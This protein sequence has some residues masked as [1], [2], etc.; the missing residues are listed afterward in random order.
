[1]GE[2]G[3][4]LITGACGGLGGAF[5]R[6]LAARGEPLFL[7]G[8]DQT[9]LSAL[10]DKLRAEYPDLPVRYAACDLTDGNSRLALFAATDASRV[11][12]RRLIY[13]AGADIQ[14]AFER[15]DE[16]KLVFQTRVNFEGAV[17]II[18]GVT[19]RAAMDGTTELLTVGSMSGNCPMPYFVLYSAAKKALEQFSVALRVEL[20]GRAKVTCILPGSMPTR[21][22]IKKNI[23]EHGFWTRISALPPEKVAAAAL[24]AVK[25][26][27][28]TKTIGFWNHIIRFGTRLAPRSL[29]LRF[30]ARRWKKTEKDAF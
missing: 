29:Q 14:K 28:K 30:V 26:N 10:A 12:F 7:T 19:A 4:T 9:R 27:R 5:V 18:R 16:E 25:R 22:D 2:A 24:K 13:A 21:E 23:R 17:S 11:R 3:Y 1:M 6:L 8:R 20:K 15:Y